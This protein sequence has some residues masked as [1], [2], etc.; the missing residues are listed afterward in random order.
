MLLAATLL[1]GGCATLQPL[2]RQA[3][4]DDP[5]ALFDGL[6]P[7]LKTTKVDV[8]YVTDRVRERDGDGSHGYGI[9]RSPAL[10]WGSAQVELAEDLEWDELVDWTLSRSKSVP[11]PEPRLLA[12]DE[13][14]RFPPSPYAYRVDDRGSPVFDPAVMAQR[15][16]A[17]SALQREVRRRLDRTHREVLLVIHGI[18]E[19]LEWSVGDVAVFFH[20]FARRGVPIVYSWPSGHPGLLRGYSY[21]RESGLFTVFHL[22]ELL[23]A[24]IA[25]DDVEKIHIVAHSRGTAVITDALRELIIEQRAAGLNPREEMRLANLVLLAADLD[26][27]VL[28]QRVDGEAMGPAAGRLTIYAS[29]DDTALAAS[30][31]LFS[32]DRRLGRMSSDELTERD[33]HALRRESNLDLIFY[34]GSGGGVFE[35]EYFWVPAVAA[36]LLL[37]LEGNEAGAE[38]GRPLTPL[39]PN[40]WK[41]GNDYLQ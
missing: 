7:E 14:G 15:D 28:E 10:A 39:A 23:R 9:G 25:M 2:P 20:L 27:E 33:L 1:L 36:D 13:R 6:A 31:T 38:H 30:E 21:D 34:E 4:G 22:K 40:V 26:V 11:S 35:H 24:L 8:L 41:I 18:K 5:R 29:P 32:S 17:V 37:L 16:Q 12:V 19:D 3:Y